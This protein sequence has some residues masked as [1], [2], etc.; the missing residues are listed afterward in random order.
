MPNLTSPHSGAQF[1][2]FKERDFINP[3]PWR[4]SMLSPTNSHQYASVQNLQIN[5]KQK[6]NVDLDMNEARQKV[7]VKFPVALQ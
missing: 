6:N 7:N 5:A 1:S 2:L 3:S 4:K